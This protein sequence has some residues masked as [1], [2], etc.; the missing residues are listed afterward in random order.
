MG[1][2]L[3]KSFK[4]AGPVRMNLSSRGIGWSV[5]VRGLRVGVS[6]G[7]RTYIRGGRG[8]V[9]YERTL[10]SAPRGGNRAAHAWAANVSQPLASATP[11]AVGALSPFT[12]TPAPA[13]KMSASGCLVFLATVLAL[14][15]LLVA[16]GMG[17]LVVGAVWLALVGAVSIVGR[18]RARQRQAEEQKR[19]RQIDGL[20]AAVNTLLTSPSPKEEDSR[21]VAIQRKRLGA[22]PEGTAESFEGAYRNAVAAA[23]ADQMVTTEERARLGLL[24][25]GLGLA[26]EYVRRANLGGFTEGFYALIADGKLTEEE[27]EKLKTLCE[28]FDIPQEQIVAHLAKADQLRR[29]RTI[30]QT[31]ELLPITSDLRLG[32]DEVCLYSAPA[33][34]MRYYVEEG[35]RPMRSGTVYVTNRRLLFVGD[36]TT[37]IKLE[38]LLGTNTEPKREG[39]D[40]VAAVVDGRKTPYYIDTPEPFVLIAYLN[41]VLS[42]PARA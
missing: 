12:V 41:R 5:G 6:G 14:P 18:A 30:E 11:Q 2:T 1:W 40:L 13:S 34:E 24:A 7:G 4:L 20:N 23:V 25:R 36:G 10:S 26:P 8:I 28:A 33:G 9:R 39:G 27:D 15:M 17:R 22:L 35:F 19:Q 16:E 29:A 21:R 38:K 42:A 31:E 32:K 3:R 37:S